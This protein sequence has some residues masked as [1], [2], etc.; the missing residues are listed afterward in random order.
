[1]RWSL[2]KQLI[3]IVGFIIVLSILLISAVVIR[4]ANSLMSDTEEKKTQEVVESVRSQIDVALLE[5]FLQ[6]GEQHPYYEQLRIKLDEYRK[7]SGLE[8]LYT[9][10]VQD[11]KYY[12]A[13]DGNDKSDMDNFSPFMSEESEPDDVLKDVFKEAFIH[14]EEITQTDDGT[15]ITSYAPIL[16]SQDEVIAVLGADANAEHIIVARNQFVNGVV[17]ITLIVFVLSLAIIILYSRRLSREVNRIKDGVEQLSQGNLNIE[18]GETRRKDEVKN[19]NDAILILQTQLKSFVQNLQNNSTELE[20]EGKRLNEVVEYNVVNFTQV[21]EGIEKINKQGRLQYTSM[22]QVV[23]LSEKNELSMSRI[24]NLLQELERINEIGKL[25][26]IEGEETINEVTSSIDMM[27]NQIDTSSEKVRLL[28]EELKQ[29]ENILALIND[30][31][32]QTNLLALNAS[33]EAARAGE[34]GKGFAVVADEIRKLSEATANAVEQISLLVQK[35][36]VSSNGSMIEMNEVVNQSNEN[37]QLIK[38]VEHAMKGLIDNSQLYERTLKEIET[39]QAVA[40]KNVKG[41]LNA[42]TSALDASN[43]IVGQ[44]QNVEELANIQKEENEKIN[45]TRQD[46]LKVSI[47]MKEQI[48]QFQ[49]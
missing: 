37:K 8:Y 17:K 10:I 19:L 20:R 48:A 23:D 14:T 30:I 25:S 22:Q 39:I 32:T 3:S 41:I 40:E 21:D 13:V 2:K 31:S 6:E 26:C 24:I 4:D 7:V 33:I 43:S 5:E 9:M 12:Y 47:K 35:V 1:M 36:S 27:N 16:N 11:G 46:I 34:V 38:R 42:A 29:I 45:L 49:S 44:V 18:I 15:L 28:S